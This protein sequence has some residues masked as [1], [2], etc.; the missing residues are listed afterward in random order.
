[1]R[2]SKESEGKRI[3]RIIRNGMAEAEVKNLLELS[4]ASGLDY[5]TLCR[6]MKEGEKFTVGELYLLSRVI[7]IREV[8]A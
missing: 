5:R 4:K 3:V 7:K 8:T 1:M 6:R 2:T